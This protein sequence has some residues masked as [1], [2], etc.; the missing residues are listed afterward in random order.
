MNLVIDVGNTYI[1]TALFSSNKKIIKSLRF[2]NKTKTINYI[3]SES[4]ENCII[5]SVRKDNEPLTNAILAKTSKLIFFNHKTKIPIKNL[6]K[7]P[8]TLGLDRLAGVIGAYSIFPNKNILVVDAGTAITFDFINNKA[9]YIGGNISPGLNIRFSSLHKFTD[10]LPKCEK[11][12]NFSS[13]GTD[14]CSAI[15]AGVQNGIIAE[16]EHYINSFN[17]KYD[18]LTTIITG[19]DCFFF[20]NKLK[21]TIFV[22][23][24][25]VMYGLNNI[26]IFNE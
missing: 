2:D 15:I 18:K 14:T 21:N 10:K 3:L 25:L 26:L 4:F 6:Y 22:N 23:P 20:E 19:G 17:K 13:I 8:E 12:D 5:S 24:D 1:K 16:V 11:T 9:E 7:T